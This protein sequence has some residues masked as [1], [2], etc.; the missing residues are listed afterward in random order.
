MNKQEQIK[1][2]T[3]E[4]KKKLQEI[5]DA[6]EIPSM[7]NRVALYR[8]VTPQGKTVYGNMYERSDKKYIIVDNGSDWYIDVEFVYCKK[9][10]KF[11][12]V[13][14]KNHNMVFNGDMVKYTYENSTLIGRVCK[15]WIDYG[16]LI[17]D[18]SGDKDNIAKN[19]EFVRFEKDDESHLEL[20]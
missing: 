2:L 6:P 4:Y 15:Q 19:G 12:G 8:G 3:A 10:Q 14:D 7:E 1:N 16:M 13:Y 11:I 20:I 18:D 9:I 5:I 17:T